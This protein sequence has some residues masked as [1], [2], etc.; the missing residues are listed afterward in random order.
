M[1]YDR[2]AQGLSD[3]RT[4]TNASSPAEKLALFRALFRGREDV[5]ARRWEN[6]KTGK[7]G[8]SPICAV[9][10]VRGVCGKASGKANCA[11]CPTRQFR[12]LDDAA[13][14]AHLRGVDAAGKLF[15]LGCY[16]LLTDDAVRFA[17][18]DF[19]KSSW[20]SDSASV[21]DVFRGFGWP[22]A[23]ERS[24]S[25]NGAHLWFFFAEPQPARF[26]REALTYVLTLAMERNPQVGLDSYDRI[27]PNQD[28]MPKG[29]FGN[30]IALP[31]QGGPRRAGNSCFV[32]ERLV[33]YADQWHFL[34]SVPL[35]T[36]EAV[37]ALRMRAQS[38]KRLLLPQREEEIERLEPWT[39]FLPDGKRATEPY[40]LPEDH[41]SERVQITLG[42]AVYLR[43]NELTPSVRGKLIRLASF[44]NPEYADK[45]RLRVNVYNTP[46]VIDKSING[47]DFLILPRGCLENALKTLKSEGAQW[48]LADKRQLGTP[49]DV[50]FVGELREEQRLAA[51]A[52]VKHDTGVLAAGT[53][54]GKTVLAAWMIAERKTNTLVLVNRAPLQQ[55]W[56]ERLL[57]FLGIPKKEIGRFGGAAKK[58]NGKLDVA[59][60]QS[61]K[62][63]DGEFLVNA[64]KDYGQIIIDECHAVPAASFEK[65]AVAAS[66]KYFLG[67]SAT[68]V[69][70][71]GRHPVVEMLCG[72]VRHRVDATH[73]DNFA[74]FRHV[75]RVRTT[76][77]VPKTG[78][79]ADEGEVRFADVVAEMA[80]N[81]KRNDMIVRDVLAA[82]KEGRSPVILTERREHIDVLLRLLEGRADHVIALRG[83]M[84]RK[85]Q[86]KCREDLANIPPQSSR[87]LIATGAYLGEGFDDAR[88]DTLFL[89]LPISWKGRVT[90]YAGRL[91]RMSDGKREV[92][93]YDYVDTR[94]GFAMKMFNRRCKAYTNIGYEIVMANDAF[95]G[96]PEGAELPVALRENETYAAT[97][98]R[99]AKEGVD[100]ETADL[101]VTAATVEPGQARS[102][103]ERFLFKFLD[104]LPKTKGLFTL[105]GKLEIPFGPNS[106]M[107]VD[108]LCTTRK[109]AIEVDGKLHFAAPE[110]YRRDRR[111]DYLLQKHGYTV[112]RFLAEDVLERIDDVMNVI[113]DCVEHSSY[114]S[115]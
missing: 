59:L 12:A 64:V 33:P 31:L 90:Q 1:G 39:L 61:L 38:E 30:L 101:F 52:L 15:T 77:F 87:I 3:G 98:K 95:E 24:R 35:V 83:G 40:E 19:D 69:R 13:V 47:D 17:A 55:Q 32:D 100:N 18:I 78:D 7:I 71:D 22:A 49:L 65:V 108:L 2:M 111:K 102:A 48:D 106:T 109:I 92:R 113:D 72:P 79:V 51:N 14:E 34:S 99:L 11:T 8:Y 97:I 45:Q 75:V 43:Q 74:S 20:R 63:L 84:G 21:M 82:V 88:L 70:K 103:A 44:V 5:Y 68:V 110:N 81:A 80:D 29:G 58:P 114:K 27:F 9:E 4:V 96:W 50:A 56:I 54:F 67:L 85:M 25:G 10:W 46:C 60:V 42:N 94:V 107:E 105:N 91:H 104:G 93:I 6:P 89:T 28:R 73:M 36:T 86:K 37:T 16:P 23:R 112:L 66:A 26:V 115:S 53:A 62:N 57:Q 41:I 76:P